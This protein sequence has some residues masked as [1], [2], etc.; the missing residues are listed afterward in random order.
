MG[1]SDSGSSH[2]S[3][4][5]T[6]QTAESTVDEDE[7]RS[8]ADDI[9]EADVIACQIRMSTYLSDEY[10]SEEEDDD[11][12]AEVSHSEIEPGLVRR[13]E[14]DSSATARY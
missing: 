9:D 3:G 6:P 10:D 2:A 5:T 1:G 11:D 12:I 13:K 8:N 7:S 4:G 14:E